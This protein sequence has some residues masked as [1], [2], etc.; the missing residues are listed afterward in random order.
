MD[1]FLIRFNGNDYL[2]TYNSETG[3][4]EAEIQ[5][6]ETGGIYTAEYT[7]TDVFGQRLEDSQDVQVFAKEQLKLN[8]NKVFM[9][10]FDCYT[11]EVKDIVEISDYELNIDEE[12]NANSFISILKTTSAKAQD[13]VAVKKNNETVYWGIIDNIE[14]EDGKQ[15][16]KYTLKYITNLFDQTIKLENENIIKTTGIEDF[17]EQAINSNFIENSDTFVNKNYLE[18]VV[19]TH[20]TKQTS[21]SNVQDGIYNLHTWMTNC[22]QNYNVVYDFNIVNGKLV[23]TIELKDYQKELIDVKA[24]PISNYSEVFETKIVSK[25]VVLT[26]TNTYTLYL[27]NDRTTTTDGTNPNRAAGR[28]ETVYTENYED[29]PQKALDTIKANTYNHNITFK[30]LDRFIKIGTPIAIKTKKS[31]IYDT[32]ISSIKITPKNFIEYICGNIRIGFIEKL[33]QERNK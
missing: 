24:Q 3:Y 26:S 23:M 28:T 1:Q 29:A 32:Y 31:I 15:L 30:Y 27:L 6:P 9:W 14:N 19:N 10:I 8:M 12:T 2:A 18:L 13:I 25:V 5:A 11:F 4:Y 22:T 33:N 7:I 20:T 16:Y 17:I 21:V